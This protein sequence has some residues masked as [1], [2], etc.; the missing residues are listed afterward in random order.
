MK[1]LRI[2][3]ISDIHQ[4]FQGIEDAD[5]LFITRFKYFRWTKADWMNPL[6]SK[7][8][9]FE[10]YFQ[11]FWRL[12][13][14]EGQTHFRQMKGKINII[15]SSLTVYWQE[16]FKSLRKLSL[17]FWVFLC[18]RWEV[19]ISNVLEWSENCSLDDAFGT[20]DDINDDLR[21]RLAD[22]SV[23]FLQAQP[24]FFFWS[25]ANHFWF[26]LNV[27]FPRKDQLIATKSVLLWWIFAAVIILFEMFL[28]H[29]LGKME[30]HLYSKWKCKS[31]I[32]NWNTWRRTCFSLMGEFVP[33]ILPPFH[34]VFVLQSFSKQILSQINP[35]G[36]LFP[37]K[38]FPVCLQWKTLP[39]STYD[40]FIFSESN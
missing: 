4:N 1:L 10:F 35:I 13:K 8:L 11:L 5:C 16:L 34:V 18:C 33:M 25:F 21:R 26:Q 17:C 15:F 7:R 27:T 24:A 23:C 12:H 32:E 30:I 36:R 6:I 29:I 38:T 19:A 39:F 9:S 37:C 14:V 2:S 31:P 22:A 20:V 3:L 40:S 28:R